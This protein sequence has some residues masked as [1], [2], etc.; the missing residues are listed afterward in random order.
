MPSL[1]LTN[2]VPHTT[3]TTIPTRIP[4]SARTIQFMEF[5]YY[6]DRFAVEALEMKTTKFQPLVNNATT[7]EWTITPIMVL[8]AGA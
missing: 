5:T 1:N 2:Y 6:N 7:K 3:P 8:L 4:T